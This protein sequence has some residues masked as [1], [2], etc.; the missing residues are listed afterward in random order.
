MA[1]YKG[2]EVTVI[3]E[4]P[5]GGEAQVEIEHKD[6]A[7]LREIVAKNQVI[8]NK[9]EKKAIDKV[10]EDKDKSE[11]DAKVLNDFRVEGVNDDFVTP[12]P[13]VKEVQ[14]Q[15][16][17]EAGIVKAEQDKQKREDWEKKHPNAP[18]GAYQGLEAIKVVPY[19]EETEK[20][21]KDHK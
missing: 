21:L 11:K 15:R 13:S 1:K 17:A 3:Q 16:N 9:D 8:L 18:A 14:V 10:R 4:I 5:F 6:L 12:L 7:G 19:K 2:R 20:A